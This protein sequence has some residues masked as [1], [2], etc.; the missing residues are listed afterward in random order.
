MD[1][2]GNR[3]LRPVNGPNATI[4][5]A[6]LQRPQG[7]TLA[8]GETLH[9]IASGESLSAICARHYG[10]RSLV[11]ALARHNKL[12]N[13]DLVKAGQQLR[14]PTIQT[15]AGPSAIARPQGDAAP[16]AEAKKSAAPRTYTVQQGDTLSSIAARQMGASGR[17]MALYEFNDDVIDDPDNVIAGTVI[18]I[19]Q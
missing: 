15:L 1:E 7:P 3:V 18:K 19:P 5:N 14:I 12:D 11:K 16:S 9:T 17:W 13:P 10:D 4:H 8:A 2:H 6:A